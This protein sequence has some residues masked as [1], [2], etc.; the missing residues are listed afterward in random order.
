M[1][2]KYITEALKRIWQKVKQMKYVPLAALLGI[3]LIALPKGEDEKAAENTWE[4]ETYFSLEEEELRMSRALAKIDGAG[5]VAVVLTVRST[6]KSVIAQ[7]T[8]SYTVQEDG[9]MRM[10][11]SEKAVIVSGDSRIESPVVIQTVFPIYQGALVIA[12]GAGNAE[13]RLQLTKAIANLTGLGTDKIS[14]VKMKS[15]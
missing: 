6:G 9:E 11:S 10:E 13:T 12:E 3:I 5:K 2:M 1:K 4:K 15:S 8:E 14:V 7:D